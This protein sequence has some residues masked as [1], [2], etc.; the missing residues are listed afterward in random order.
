MNEELKRAL[1]LYNDRVKFLKEK[2]ESFY[3]KDKLSFYKMLDSYNYFND[4]LTENDFKAVLR[5]KRNRA[6]RRR[7]ANKKIYAIRYLNQPTIV[8]GTCTFNDDQFFKKNGKPISEERRTRKVNEWIK[9]H[10]DYSVVNIDYG[11]KNER[12]HHHFVGVLKNTEQVELIKGKSKTGYAMYELVNKD[13]ELGFEP[14]L[15][16]VEYDPL[17]F[18]MKK[19]S[20]YL[21]KINNHE[22]KDTTKNRRFRVLSS[23]EFV[24]TNSI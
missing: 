18:R 1:A 20:N 7:R 8:F 2:N 23:T 10:F 12:E 24:L 19:L 14:T 13:Y 3:S 4:I 16:L 21:L 6:N 11:K 5:H 9:K 15:E 17:D 22:N